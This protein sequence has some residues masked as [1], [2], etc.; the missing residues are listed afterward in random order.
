MGDFEHREK[1][2]R[3]AMSKIDILIPTFNR[4]IPLKKNIEIIATQ[5]TE[6]GLCD[7]VQILISDNASTDKTEDILR[8]AR[9]NPN[10]RVEVYS[11]D[12]NLGLEKNVIFLLGESAADFVMFLGDDDYLPDGYLKY[13]VKSIY[14]IK[15]LGAIIPGNSALHA[16]GRLVVARTGKDPVESHEASFLTSLKLS[17][18][19]HQ[20]SGL[21]LRRDGLY[22]DYCARPQYRNIYPFISFLA[23]NCLRGKILY[24]PCFQV[25]IT[26]FNPKDWK[27]DDSGLLTDIFKNYHLVFGWSTPKSVLSCSA[28]CLQ[29]SWRLRISRPKTAFSAFRHLWASSDVEALLKIGLPIIYTYLLA[30]KVFRVSARLLITGRLRQPAG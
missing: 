29:Q 9:V 19:G 25:A 26:V 20:L 14:E 24:A 15:E 28:F 5:I 21:L 12:K 4:A 30:R 8:E 18:F 7:E 13:L 16:D 2:Q 27:Y 1:D 10:V 6:E 23:W 11:Q 22:D 17:K 3:Q